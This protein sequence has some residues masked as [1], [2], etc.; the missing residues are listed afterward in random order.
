M[1]KQ[2]N[3]ARKKIIWLASY[4]KSGNTWLRAF[5]TAL[6]NGDVDINKLE[7]DGIFSARVRFDT[8]S[9]LDSSLLTDDESKTLLGT[10]FNHLSVTTAKERL[11]V[12]VHDAYTFLPNGKPLIPTESTSCA[13]YLIRN[14]LDIAASLASHRDD[15]IDSS[16]EMLNDNNCRFSAQN[17]QF[18][19]QPQFEQRLLNWSEHVLSWTTKPPFPVLVLRYEDMLADTLNIFYKAVKFMGIRANLQQI[20]TAM[21]ASSFEQLQKNEKNADFVERQK[22]NPFFRRGTSENWRTELNSDQINTITKKHGKIM[23]KYGY[24]IDK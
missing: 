8:Y 3:G 23:Q 20:E 6:K 12:K 19:T 18:N 11:F 17:N 2:F 14:P 7:T 21:A 13:I 22:N 15:T 16:I 24:S 10:I 1:S 4:P 9:G 5:I